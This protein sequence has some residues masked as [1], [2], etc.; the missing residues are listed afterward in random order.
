MKPS[1][2][3]DGNP[4][5]RTFR[6]VMGLVSHPEVGVKKQ[7]LNV[8][9]PHYQSMS[10]HSDGPC[11]LKN[12]PQKLRPRDPS[13]KSQWKSMS[14]GTPGHSSMLNHKVERKRQ[15]Q[16]IKE[17]Y[18]KSPQQLWQTHRTTMTTGRS[19]DYTARSAN[20]RWEDKTGNT[21]RSVSSSH[22]SRLYQV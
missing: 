15:I 22:R 20:G 18:S 1:L 4:G 9:G 21:A 8:G 2:A 19:E 13:D 14:L 3:A 16:K 17:S 5:Y 7:P 11:T 12:R 6:Q 10:M